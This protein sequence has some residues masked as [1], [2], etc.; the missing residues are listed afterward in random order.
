MST[1]RCTAF[2]VY[3]QTMQANQLTS[4]VRL[5]RRSYSDI[6]L[7]HTYT[8]TQQRPLHH[9]SHQGFVGSRSQCVEYTLETRLDTPTQ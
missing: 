7:T 1:R 4:F 9:C 3:S 5:S 2:F 6:A 8:H